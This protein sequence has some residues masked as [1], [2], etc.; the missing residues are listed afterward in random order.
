MATVE[1][2]E[3]LL[4]RAVERAKKKKAKQKAY[5]ET[6]KDKFSAQQKKYYRG[7]LEYYRE[8]NRNY[9]LNNKMKFRDYQREHRNKIKFQNQFELPLNFAEEA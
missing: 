1:K 5:Y 7:H 9:R 3:D 8:Y 6:N 4:S 2:T